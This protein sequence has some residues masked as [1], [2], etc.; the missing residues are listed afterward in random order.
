ME[1]MSQIK[2]GVSLRV[3]QKIVEGKKDRIVTFQGKVVNVRGVGDNKMITV[4]AAMDGVEVE[5][6]YPLSLPTIVKFEIIEDKKTGKKAS[7]K[8]SKRK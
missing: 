2:K 5:R 6:I 1:P 4:K 8:T 7:R 3:L